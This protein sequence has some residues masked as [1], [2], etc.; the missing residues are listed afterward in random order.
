MV[1]VYD[2]TDAPAMP[3]EINGM[4]VIRSKRGHTP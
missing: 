1:V 4:A 3:A 2:R